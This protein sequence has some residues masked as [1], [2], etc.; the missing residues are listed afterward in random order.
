MDIIVIART[1]SLLQL[2]IYDTVGI[3]SHLSAYQICRTMHNKVV[4]LSQLHSKSVYY[5]HSNRGDSN[6]YIVMKSHVHNNCS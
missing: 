1:I 4:L 3:N 2:D 6:T 5:P